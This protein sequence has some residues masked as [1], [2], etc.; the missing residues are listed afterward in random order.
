VESSNLYAKRRYADMAVLL[1]MGFPTDYCGYARYYTVK[2]RQTFGVVRHQCA[3]GPL[4]SFAHELAHMYGC[5][6]NTEEHD[7]DPTTQL[8]FPYSHGKLFAP[9]YKTIMR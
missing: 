4:F 8:F 7:A 9:S 3:N 5:Q 6:H 2:M 1:M